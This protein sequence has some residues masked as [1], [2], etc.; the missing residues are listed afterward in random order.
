MAAAIVQA[1]DVL[2]VDQIGAA[3]SAGQGFFL[4]RN[5]DD[6]DVIGHQA[7]AQDGEAVFQGVF[8]KQPQVLVL[9]LVQEKDILAII[10]T[11]GDVMWK[12]G[13]DYS[14]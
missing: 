2:G 1:V 13:H 8:L 6:V 9:V 14:G 4:V 7:V 11:L 3:D 10:A 12:T 5:A